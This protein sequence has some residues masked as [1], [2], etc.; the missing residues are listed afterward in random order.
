MNR[1]KNKI[2]MKQKQ[3]VVLLSFLSFK[4]LNIR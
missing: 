3:L 4:N 1:E 2:K